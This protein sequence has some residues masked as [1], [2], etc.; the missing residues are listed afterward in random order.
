MLNNRFSAVPCQNIDDYAIHKFIEHFHGL[1]IYIAD[2][3]RIKYYTSDQKKNRIRHF[4]L[5][6]DGAYIWRKVKPK[7]AYYGRM[8][9]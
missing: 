5:Y 4:K 8:I 9:L 2:I 7:Y 3:H 6:L 1:W